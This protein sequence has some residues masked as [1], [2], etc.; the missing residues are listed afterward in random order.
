MAYGRRSTA[1]S[2]SEAFTLN[3]VPYPVLVI[4]AV[5]FIFLGGHW[6]F[7]FEDF[8][9]SAQEQLGWILLAA[10]L[11][12]LVVVRWLPTSAEDQAG[13]FGGSQWGSAGRIASL[14]REAHRGASLL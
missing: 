4:L 10:P 9:E 11:I 5:I 8:M 12:L 14:P 13:F 7:S 3:P 2:I 1:S 6:Y